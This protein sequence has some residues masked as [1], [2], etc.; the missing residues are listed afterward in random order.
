MSCLKGEQRL[1]HFST[2]IKVLPLENDDSVTEEENDIIVKIYNNLYY[3]LLFVLLF[4]LLCWL[5]L[6]SQHYCSNI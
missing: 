3:I 2:A 6:L 1:L 4:V 5:Y